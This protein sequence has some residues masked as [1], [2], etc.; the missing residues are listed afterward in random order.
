MSSQADR[1]GGPHLER[2]TECWEYPCWNLFGRHPKIVVIQLTV[3]VGE[4]LHDVAWG[5]F[6]FNELGKFG[7]RSQ[8]T[9]SCEGVG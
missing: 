2:P 6:G 8:M 7:V 4:L 9:H 5:Q 1:S 3:L